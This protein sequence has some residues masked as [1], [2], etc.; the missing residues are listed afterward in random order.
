MPTTMTDLLKAHGQKPADVAALDSMRSD[1]LRGRFDTAR[2][3]TTLGFDQGTRASADGRTLL[4][5]LALAGASTADLRACVS[6]GADPKATDG[7]G[8]TPAQLA[9]RRGH[10]TQADAL[11]AL[12]RE[13]ERRTTRPAPTADAQSAQPEATTAAPKRRVW[14][15]QATGSRPADAASA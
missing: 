1:I 2:A 14:R 7:D 13:A 9:R 6:H 5:L 3:R 15:P 11:E 4:H 8:R 12:E 10:H